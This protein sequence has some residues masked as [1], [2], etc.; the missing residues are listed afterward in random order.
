EAYQQIRIPALSLRADYANTVTRRVRGWLNTNAAVRELEG[1]LFRSRLSVEGSASAGYIPSSA[2]N[3]QPSTPNRASETQLL[4]FCARLFS[5]HKGLADQK[6][7]HVAG[8]H[9]GHI[10]AA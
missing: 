4:Q 5:T 10:V 7:I 2:P 3:A 6:R 1:W 8:A 9:C